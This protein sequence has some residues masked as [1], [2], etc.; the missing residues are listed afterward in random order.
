[1]AL[2]DC[3]ALEE[4]QYPSLVFLAFVRCANADVKRITVG[5]AAIVEFVVGIEK[6]LDL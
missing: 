3:M 5:M 6:V 2:L 4:D 1:M